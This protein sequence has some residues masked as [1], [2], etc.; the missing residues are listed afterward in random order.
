MATLRENPI[1]GQTISM[2]GRDFIVP[3]L[4]LPLVKRYIQDVEA[5]QQNKEA[6]LQ[7]YW[8]L[9]YGTI[10]AAMKRN[11]PDLTMD[12]L[13]ELVDMNNLVDVFKA[14]AGKSGLILGEALGGALRLLS[15]STGMASTATSSP[16]PAGAGKTLTS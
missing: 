13:Y 7:D 11:Y 9:Q 16:A 14:I 15:Q 10:H 2:G 12:E 4:T 5:L 3:A 6:P 1:E 8:D